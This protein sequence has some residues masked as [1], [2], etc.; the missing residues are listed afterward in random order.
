[1]TV[2]RQDIV[3]VARSYI[4]TPWHHMGRTPGHSLDC[5]G[6]LICVARELGVVQP[7]FDIPAYTQRPDGHSFLEWCDQ[8]MTKIPQADMG[9]GD[10]IVTKLDLAPQHMGIVGD[11]RYGGFSIIHSC[12][13]RSVVPS[14][15]IETGLVFSRVMKFVAAYQLPGVE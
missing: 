11:Y 14:R 7:D 4:G 10:V 9:F 12:N 6:L 2:P 13:A 3:M 5:A 15:V 8:H 1:M